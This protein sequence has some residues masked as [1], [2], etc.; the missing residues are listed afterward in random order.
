MAFINPFDYFIAAFP[1]E[2]DVDVRGNVSPRIEE[3]L[4]EKIAFNRV[5][6]S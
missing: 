4:E 2:I 1:A 3:S 5:N 6:V